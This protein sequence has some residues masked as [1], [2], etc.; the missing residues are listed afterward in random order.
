[1][2][3]YDTPTAENLPAYRA[4]PVSGNEINGQ[5]IKEKVRARRVFHAPWNREMAWTGMN[6]FFLMN[7]T[8]AI[9]VQA[10][11]NR[12]LMRRCAGPVAKRRVEAG[13]PE[14][15]ARRLKQKAKELGA[16]IVGITEIEPGDLYDDMEQ[17]HRYAICIGIP[18]RREEMQH[19]PHE[20]SGLE[21]QRVYGE[22]ARVSIELAEYIRAMGW[23][24]YAHGDP[25]STEVLQI[26]MAVRAGLGQ[27]G[28]HGSMISKE[29]GSNFRLS[30]VATDIPLSL[31]NPVDIGVDDLC[32]GCRRCTIDCPPDA[33]ADEKQ[34]VRGEYRWYVDFDKCV[35]YFTTTFGCAICIEVCPWSEP[36]R[37]PKLSQVLLAKRSKKAQ[38][39]GAENLGSE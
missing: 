17:K 3:L 29:Y 13:D 6:D 12:W 10:L 38:S 39:P 19:V 15:M 2:K 5:G 23:P 21:V 24:A 8:W 27:L 16:G 14:E 36:G 30:A 7:N 11:K 22:V 37:G 26:P 1:M 20:R 33:I 4:Q 18:M 32:L 31:D 25:R 28:K 35:P 34:W 9:L